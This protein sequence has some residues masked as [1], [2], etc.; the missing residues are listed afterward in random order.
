VRSAEGDRTSTS[1]QITHPPGS[2][3][4]FENQ[5]PEADR[6]LSAR[7]QVHPIRC[8]GYYWRIAVLHLLGLPYQ[9]DLRS[10]TGKF[11]L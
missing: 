1:R 6:R 8:D 10:K 5:S 4:A 9:C 2:R 7:K 11:Q 3:S